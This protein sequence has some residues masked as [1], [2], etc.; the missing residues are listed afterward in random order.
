M[1]QNVPIE[2]I[3]AIKRERQYNLDSI[4]LPKSWSPFI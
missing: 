2:K 1:K 3:N 4:N